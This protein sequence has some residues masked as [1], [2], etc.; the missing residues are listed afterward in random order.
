M[1]DS[2]QS[3]A[4]NHASRRLTCVD[5]PFNTSS[6]VCKE[7]VNVIITRLY[8]SSSR[9][10]RQSARGARRIRLHPSGQR[11]QPSQTIRQ[12]PDLRAP[13]TPPRPTPRVHTRVYTRVAC[14]VHSSRTLVSKRSTPSSSTVASAAEPSHRTTWYCAPAGRPPTTM[15][16]APSTTPRFTGYA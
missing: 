5:P 14:V 2:T 11:R 12:G 6:C 3:S 1:V 8:F 10:R 15:A 13:Y 7:P 16:R 9:H 4:S